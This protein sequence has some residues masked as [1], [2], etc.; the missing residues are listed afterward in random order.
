MPQVRKLIHIVADY[1]TPGNRREL[2]LGLKHQLQTNAEVVC[3]SEHPTA[4]AAVLGCRI[5][6][7]F[8]T[9][10]PY[11]GTLVIV[12]PERQLHP[13]A[14]HSAA[15]RI[16]IVC[17]TAEPETLYRQLAYLRDSRLPE[18]ELSFVSRHLR[19]A[20]GLPGTVNASTVPVED[21]LP[22]V[23]NSIPVIGRHSRDL[24]SEHHP[25]DPSLYRQLTLQGFDVKI[26]GGL[27]LTHLLAADQDGVSLLPFREEHVSEFLRGIDIYFYRT[28]EH[29]ANPAPRAIIE[30]LAA[31]CA[32]VASNS[33]EHSDWIRDG[34]N[35]FLVKSDEE[36]YRR[37]TELAN[38]RVLRD[39]FSEA[40]RQTAIEISG[41]VR[42]A[43]IAQ[44][45]IGPT[46]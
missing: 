29:F 9:E 26:L 32:I 5:I 21:F 42:R 24:L 31:G 28:S 44:W 23:E 34:E 6:R 3:W 37:I 38:E 25:G 20:F 4:V 45:F 2:A 39:R 40:A 12:G 14:E 19:D 22:R 11:R 43:E 10:Y 35:G 36:A 15:E 27:C 46:D 33:T 16:I 8:A 41:S 1:T 13:W 30:A 18:P 7:P 17:D